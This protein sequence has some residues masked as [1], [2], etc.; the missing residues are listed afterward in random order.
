MVTVEGGSVRVQGSFGGT[1]MGHSLPG[2]PV[3]Q[4]IV[5]VWVYVAPARVAN[6]ALGRS[7]GGMYMSA[8]R[9]ET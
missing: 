1:Y 9:G 8:P 7:A 6:G 5:T 2:V 4:G 3:L